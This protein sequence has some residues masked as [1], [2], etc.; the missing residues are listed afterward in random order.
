M[1]TVVLAI[2]GSIAAY[3]AV[4]V[5]RRL[6]KR[7]WRV[8]P[9][10]TASGQRFLGPALLEGICG[11]T[12]HTDMWGG[13]GGERH[14]ALAAEADVVAL[15]PATADLLAA[16][17]LGRCDNLVRAVALCARGPVLAAP[18]MHPRMWHH[19]ATARNVARLVA[20]DR[21][22]LVGPV[23]GPVASG[24][25]GMG[26]LADP[27]TIVAAIVRAAEPVARDL[28]GRHVVVTA[29]PTVEDV[30]PARYVSNRSSGR[31]GFAVAERAAARGARVTLIAGPVALATP[32]GVTSRLDVRSARELAAALDGALGASLGEADALVMAAAVADYRPASARQ[33]KMKRD[34]D[35]LTLTLEKNDDV[36][37]AIG[38]R[39]RGRLPWL[40]GFALESVADDEGLVARA[41]DKLTRK[42]VDLI[43]ANRPDA[44]DGDTSRVWLVTGDEAE[45]RPLQAKASVADA[46]LDRI[47]A[48]LGTEART[49]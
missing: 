26:R 46:L 31:T 44:F 5:A 33:E 6:L 2:S 18:A 21:V 7:G 29:G 28:E 12:C 32:P 43:V 39:R 13:G 10:L 36:L 27:D 38:A 22:R 35:T 30:D 20:D 3:K 40:V 48:A 17:A 19:P 47:V 37:A 41:R 14:V 23:A 8:I 4:E 25:E 1:K 45:A 15:V 49:A 9:V 11:E 24:D 16:L 42:R 34:A